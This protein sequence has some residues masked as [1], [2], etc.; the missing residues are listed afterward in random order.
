MWGFP[1]HSYLHN[2][3]HEMH[4][5]QPS[6]M[7]QTLFLVQHYSIADS[8]AKYRQFFQMGCRIL[9]FLLI[10]SQNFEKLYK[11]K[12]FDNLFLYAMLEY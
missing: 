7:I 3:T 2:E 1:G 11:I 10:K 8:N 5:I 4:S 12:L 9:G 6:I